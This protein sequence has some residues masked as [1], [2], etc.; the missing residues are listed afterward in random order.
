MR[1][2]DSLKKGTFTRFAAK[3]GKSVQQMA[4]EVKA[5]PEDYTKLEQE[6]ARFAQVARKWHHK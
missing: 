5:H 6:R 4:A 3:H 2:L 1:F